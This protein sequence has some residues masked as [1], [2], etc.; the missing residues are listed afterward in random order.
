VLKNGHVEAQGTLAFLLDSS[1][2]MRALWHDPYD[3]SP[4]L[5]SPRATD[6]EGPPPVMSR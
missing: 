2:E 1:A 6:G 4:Q 3:P 5:N